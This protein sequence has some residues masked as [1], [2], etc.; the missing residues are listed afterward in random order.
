M[1]RIKVV[2]YSCNYT[3]KKMNESPSI[4][5]NIEKTKPDMKNIV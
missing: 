1:L 5:E 4:K 2:G 3:G